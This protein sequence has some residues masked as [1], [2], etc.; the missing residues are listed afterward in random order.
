MKEAAYFT[1][2]VAIQI[3]D[4]LTS[5]KDLS[6]G[7]EQKKEALSVDSSRIEVS[8][9]QTSREVRGELVQAPIIIEE[10]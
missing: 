4:L 7:L 2:P 3:G 10:E 6:T 9:H 5:R 8:S 1:M